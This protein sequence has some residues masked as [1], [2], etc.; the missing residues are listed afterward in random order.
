MLLSIGLWII[1]GEDIGMVRK[2]RLDRKTVE[3]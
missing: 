1:I 3:K 2:M